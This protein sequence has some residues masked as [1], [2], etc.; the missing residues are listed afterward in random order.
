MSELT[1]THTRLDGTLIDGTRRDDG[2]SAVLKANGWRWSR[3]LGSWYVPQTRDR[4]AKTRLIDNT[5]AQLRTAGFTV[6]VD[7]D[8]HA[9][10]TA[11]VV[12]DQDARQADRVAALQAKAQSRHEQAADAQ[13]RMNRAHDALPPFGEPIKVGHHSERRHRRSI[14]KAFDTLGKSVEADRTAREAD[15]RADTATNTTAHR[16]NPGVIA[17]RLDKLRADLRRAERTRD[18]HTRTLFTSS[19]TGYKHVET[20]PA[21][22]GAHREQVLARIA[23]LIDQIT[24]WQSEL[25]AARE[26]GTVLYDRTMIRPGDIVCLGRDQWRRVV[27]VNP[28]T[29]ACET[30]MPWPLKTGY[31]RITDVRD[32]T[33]QPVTFCDGIR[34]APA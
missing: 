1:I 12:T 14:E 23:E 16:H 4:A 8:D 28:K 11:D 19:Q 34:Q 31:E 10:P 9:R 13:A 2:S 25:D 26:A 24:Y 15:R 7:I 21:A 30:D 33:G 20:T 27:K 3:A 22:T 6:T 32:A 29:I 18:G 5:A 17:R